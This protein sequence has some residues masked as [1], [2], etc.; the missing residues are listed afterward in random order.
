MAKYEKRFLNSQQRFSN[1]NFF[2]PSI[3]SLLLQSKLVHVLIMSSRSTLV[4]SEWANMEASQWKAY[5]PDTK[6]ILAKGKESFTVNSLNVI[7]ESL[8]TKNFKGL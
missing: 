4:I 1:S 8:R 3:T 2:I 7:E 5:Y 6:K